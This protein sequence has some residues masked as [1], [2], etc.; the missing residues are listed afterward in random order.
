MADQ[1][2]EMEKINKRLEALE[3]RLA[4]VES[5]LKTSNGEISTFSAEELRPSGLCRL[6]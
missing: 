3:I 1:D 2:S 6:Q 5:S 4:G